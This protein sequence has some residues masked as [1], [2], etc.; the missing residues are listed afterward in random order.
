MSRTKVLYCTDYDSAE[1]TLLQRLY[2]SK[3]ENH[4][5]TNVAKRKKGTRRLYGLDGRPVLTTT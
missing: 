5:E 3:T 1:R 2:K 4:W